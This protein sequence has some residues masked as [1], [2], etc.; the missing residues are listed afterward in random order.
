MPDL[1][2][3]HSLHRKKD[4]L[5]DHVWLLLFEANLLAQV[6]LPTCPMAFPKAF[7]D[8]SARLHDFLTQAA[9]YRNFFRD[10]L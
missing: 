10:I 2:Q 7:N 1:S 8:D 6:C 4:K 3:N 9:S 5:M